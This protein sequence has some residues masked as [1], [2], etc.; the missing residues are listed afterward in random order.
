MA[1]KFRNILRSKV[2][3]AFLAYYLVFILAMLWTEDVVAGWKMVNRQT[4]F[5]LFPLFWSSA[6][7]EYRERYISAFIAGL[8]L[9]AVFAHYNF[10]QLYW[11]PDWPRGVRV[12]KSVGDTSP[13]IDWLNY[14]PILG[15]G[16]YFSLRR[17]VFAVSTSARLQAIAITSLLVSNLAFSRGRAGMAIFVVLCIALVFER[18]TARR[19]ALLLCAIVVPLAFVT[20]YKT[21]G[22]FAERI[23]NAVSDIRVF[24]Q[25]PNTSIGQRLVFWTT[26]FQLFIQHPALGVGSGDFNKEYAKNKPARWG[27]TPDIRNPHN[28]FLMTAA[29]TGLLGLAALFLVFFSAATS[30]NDARIKATLIGFA[31]ICLVESYLWRSNTALTFSV[32]LAALLAD[33]RM[34]P[35]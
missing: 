10:M 19:T 20:A 23:D 4:P 29:T 21:S 1:E 3:L 28:Q 18:V 6:Q 31:V 34:E 24:E 30:G 35:E 33:S 2:C 12:F 15:L 27:I 17:A 9:C 5:L 14:A 11:F 25:N 13:F 16:A 32:I 8:S 26:S 22:I 7:P